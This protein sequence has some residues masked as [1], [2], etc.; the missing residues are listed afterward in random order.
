M[1]E[2]CL[3][4]ASCRARLDELGQWCGQTFILSPARHALQLRVIRAREQESTCDL[5]VLGLK[6]PHQHCGCHMRR[7][8]RLSGQDD[9]LWISTEAVVGVMVHGAVEV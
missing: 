4:L 1:P 2:L 8:G 5:P 9:G 3:N 7:A 6:T